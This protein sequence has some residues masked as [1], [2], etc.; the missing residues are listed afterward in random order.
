[1][2]SRGRNLRRTRPRP[3]TG[4][5]FP[6]SR[7]RSAAR[8]LHRADRHL[9]P[10]ALGCTPVAR[11]SGLRPPAP[12]R[13]SIGHPCAL[14]ACSAETDLRRIEPRLRRSRD[15]ATAW[16]RL[17]SCLPHLLMG[18][19]HL[20]VGPRRGGPPGCPP[21]KGRDR[22]RHSLRHGTAPR[23]WSGSAPRR[24][25]SPSRAHAHCAWC[26]R[27]GFDPPP[28][29]RVDEHLPRMH[30]LGDRAA[31][32]RRSP[33]RRQP[34]ARSQCHRPAQSH[35]PRPQMARRPAPART[36]LHGRAPLL[37]GTGPDSVG[38]T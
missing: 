9:R 12:N 37:R 26:H 38:L 10:S 31:R 14:I 13:I 19:D 23:S 24:Q 36:P 20:Q 1:M 30:R 18:L 28:A 33:S 22:G 17:R 5:A 2:G 34:A 29:H 6:N 27:T 21:R 11:W 25:A 4:I 16:R 15:R 3:K 8:P 32:A 7:R 35:Q